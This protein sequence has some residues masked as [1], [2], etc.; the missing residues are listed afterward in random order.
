MPASNMDNLDELPNDQLRLRLLEYGL[1]NMP[2]TTTT[3]GVL[4]KK[5]RNVMQGAET[6][7]RRETI[8]VTKYSS[9]EDSE[10]DNVAAAAVVAPKK[11]VKT[12]RRATIAAPV[13]PKSLPLPKLPGPVP[14]PAVKPINTR[15]LS[16]RRTPSAEPA[17]KA[18]PVSV[19]P[20]IIDI[21]EDSD[22]DVPVYVAPT[23]RN[24]S[25]S[26]S[27]AKSET[28]RT[29]FKHISQN[30]PPK[31]IIE[32]EPEEEY[33]E[34]D[35]ESSV[36]A[37]IRKYTDSRNLQF[38]N[39]PIKNSNYE[40]IV[41]QSIAGYSTN[42]GDSSTR[43]SM[44]KSFNTYKPDIQ[45]RRNTMSTTSYDLYN[46]G[47]HDEDNMNDE[48]L[49]TPYLSDFTRRLK[50]LQAE[51]LANESSAKLRQDLGLAGENVYAYRTSD[52]VQGRQPISTKIDASDTVWASFVTLL[53]AFEQRY[54][55]YII[56]I[57]FAFIALFI[58]VMLFAQI[59]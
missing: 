20:S 4:I 8:H 17:T 11:T 25:R 57:V 36:D 54:R 51:P 46:D 1:A 50:R 10:I 12:N 53:K 7:T 41:R 40:P 42:Y 39:S 5:L 18:Q 34:E 13:A 19:A 44:S 38:R 24:K 55:W 15:R 56:A 59:H 47:N 52:R 30:T 27:L 22:E 9:G 33:E 26:S 6:K 43:A 2:V 32:N 35:L 3:R 45:P 58:W 21:N 14:A 48:H 23:Q 31:P 29:S 28:I 37:E 16:G 49:D